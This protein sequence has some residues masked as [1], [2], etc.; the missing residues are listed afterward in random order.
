MAR[1]DSD[2]DV[3]VVVDHRD[4][5]LTDAIHGAALEVDLEHLTFLSV[6]ICPEAKLLE[7]RRLG[8]PF[9]AAVEGE[10]RV[11]WTRTS[12]AASATG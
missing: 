6:K 8:D 2:V 12:K 11:L 3:L 1:P 10:G 5:E 7:M 4:A 9:L